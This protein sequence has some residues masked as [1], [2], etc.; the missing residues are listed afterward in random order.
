MV[1]SELPLGFSKIPAERRGNKA[2]PPI[3]GLLHSNKSEWRE[4]QPFPKGTVGEEVFSQEKFQQYLKGRK[5]SPRV[6]DRPLEELWPQVGFPHA[7]HGREKE[8][9]RDFLAR[10]ANE[11]YALF[12]QQYPQ[13]P[14]ILHD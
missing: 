8:S 4:L 6:L 7:L 5:R 14:S 2:V 3:E 10:P 13:L 1:H 9:L 12:R 11:T